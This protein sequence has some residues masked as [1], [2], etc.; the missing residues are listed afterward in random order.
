MLNIGILG[1]GTVGQ[2][3]VEIISERE[4]DL[5]NL[6]GQKVN[7]KRIM[8]QDLEKDRGLDL[9]A[10]VLTNRAEDIVNDEEIQIVVEVTSSL[11][12]GYGYIKAALKNGKHVVTA[13]KA[14]LSKYFE[15]LNGLALENKR[16]LLYE[17]SV[18]GGIPVLKPLK[19]HLVLNEL[20]KLQGIL[21]GT[22]NYILSR[23][24]LEGLGYKDVLKQAQ[25]LGYAE[26][27]PAADVEGHDTLR[28]LRILGTL[29][30]QGKVSEE[31]IILEG[32]ERI[33]SFDIEK[34]KEENST[35]K[36]IGEVRKEGDGY[37]ALVMP[38]IVGMDSYF[39]NV[40]GAFNSVAFLGNN[41]GE[42]KF[43][44]PGAGKL[45]TANAILTDLI[46]I[47]LGSYRKDSL[48]GDKDL[49]NN[50]SL[51]KGRFYLRISKVNDQVK[52]ALKRIEEKNLESDDCLAVFTK[53]V[54][55]K[56]LYQMLKD[57]GIEKDQYFIARV[58][59]Q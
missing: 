2:G 27:D 6:L 59:E 44:G 12:E 54:E 37:L 21:N 11:E 4:K 46:D 25:D 10:G 29:G 51:V 47:G 52:E 53:E 31:D 9:P 20:D 39:A 22:C 7:I 43:Y 58:L 23:M 3:V 18:A 19:E 33:S 26:A 36:L 32:I 42:L 34:I 8:V 50:N 14:I 57:L 35:V 38:T 28:K 1:L 56:E 40:N 24:F 16:A 41:V 30:L 48:M 45:P 17:A 13:N 15:E 49:K 5:E 55:L